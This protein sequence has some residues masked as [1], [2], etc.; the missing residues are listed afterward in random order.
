MGYRRQSDQ[1]RVGR[2]NLA[3]G[4]DD[5][6][7]SRFADQVSRRVAI[8]D[9]RRQSRLMVV[10]L[11]ARIAQSGNFDHGLGAHAQAS[12]TREREQINPARG[13]VFAHDAGADIEPGIPQRLDQCD[14]DQVDLAQIGLG[15]IAG[16][17]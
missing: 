3:A 2:A 9:R 16:H 15:R 17:A 12:S 6:H 7:N 4:N 1:D 11:A 10:E 5:A 8:H 14:V 13:D